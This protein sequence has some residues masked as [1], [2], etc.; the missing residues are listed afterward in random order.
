MYNNFV[1]PDTSDSQHHRI[2][3]CAVLD[4]RVVHPGL[5]LVDLCDPDKVPDSLRVAHRALD[6]AVESAYGIDFG[7]NGAKIVAHLLSYT[8]ICTIPQS[9]SSSRKSLI[10]VRMPLLNAAT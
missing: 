6:A 5:S 7:E 3:E 8:K 2:E 4:T 1:W 10:G 9:V